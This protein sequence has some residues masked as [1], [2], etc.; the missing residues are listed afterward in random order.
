MSVVYQPKPID[1]SGVELAPELLELTERI[2]AN[3]H[4]VWAA[5]RITEGWKYGAIRNDEQKT[6]PCL[7][8]YEDLPESEKAYDRNTAMETLKVIS[9]LGF[10]IKKEA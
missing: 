5:A 8:K 10:E 4:D 6:H 7:V 1:T 9:L 3:V 2:A